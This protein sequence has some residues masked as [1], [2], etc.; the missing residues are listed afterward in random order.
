MQSYK[1]CKAIIF[2]ECIQNKFL[3][4]KTVLLL[5]AFS[6]TVLKP[7]AEF[8]AVY[9]AIISDRSVCVCLP[10]VFACMLI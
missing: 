2:A 7:S 4:R 9:R 10:L 8:L 1:G 5:A 3:K 6:V